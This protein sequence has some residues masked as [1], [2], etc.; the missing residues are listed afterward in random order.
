MAST[1]R[2]DLRRAK[3]LAI[4]DAVHALDLLTGVLSGFRVGTVKAATEAGMARELIENEPFD[5]IILDNELSEAEDG[6]ALTQS[7]R[8]ATGKPNHTTPVIL[9]SAN[10]PIEKVWRA[11]DAGVNLV[12]RKPIVPA[13][14]L[15][16]IE[17]LARQR[18]EFVV[19]PT[20][21][22]PDR[23]FK[24]GRLPEGVEERRAD[25]LAL[26]ERLDETMSQGD[27]DA[28]FG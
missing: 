27:V 19:A 9:L 6:I 14:L 8:Q 18:R 24:N 26:T 12:V 1:S 28:L 25:Q 3:V 2:I 4:D 23:R 16:R 5:L 7:M 20:Y 10:T 11:R 17:W 15:A 22:G 21:V 13:V